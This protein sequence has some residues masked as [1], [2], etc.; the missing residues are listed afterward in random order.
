MNPAAVVCIRARFWYNSEKSFN[1]K[2]TVT[3]KGDL[4]VRRKRMKALNLQVCR[5]QFSQSQ[6]LSKLLTLSSSL[7]VNE[8]KLRWVL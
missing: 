7:A 2:L 6:P 8:G 3:K 1:S 5:E 4:R